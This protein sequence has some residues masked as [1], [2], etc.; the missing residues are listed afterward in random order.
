MATLSVL[1]MYEHSPWI[2]ESFSLPSSID[3]NT[4]LDLIF[5]ETAELEVLYPQPDIFARI[6]G[7]WSKSRLESWGRIEKALTAEYSPIE[8]YDRT[9]THIDSYSRNLSESGTSKS[10]AS[11]TEQNKRAA[12]N[13]VEQVDSD[14]SEDASETNIQNNTKLGGNDSRNID[15]RA[16]GNIGVTTNQQM[17]NEEI[18]MR[19]TYNLYE[20]ICNNFMDKFCLGVY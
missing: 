12:F 3:R 1:A 11:G 2:F 17:I 10:T 9:E 14:S 5:S 7:S 16:H 8:N 19:S 6:L 4:L 13:S 18:K 15:I 20:I